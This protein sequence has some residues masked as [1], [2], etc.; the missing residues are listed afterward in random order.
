MVYKVSSMTARAIQRNP[1]SKPKKK[2]KLD[3]RV[4]NNHILKMGNRAKQNSQLRK[5]K[6]LRST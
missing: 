2:K 5:F 4:P 3:C 1:V 6:A